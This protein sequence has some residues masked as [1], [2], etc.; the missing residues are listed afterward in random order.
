M[1]C[2]KGILSH[3][4]KTRWSGKLIIY[5]HFYKFLL[6]AFAFEHCSWLRQGHTGIAGIDMD[7]IKLINPAQKRKPA[8]SWLQGKKKAGKNTRSVCCCFPK[9]K[10]E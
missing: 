2:H 7:R 3:V 5:Q 9:L 8:D 1:R 6:Q 10:T 4:R